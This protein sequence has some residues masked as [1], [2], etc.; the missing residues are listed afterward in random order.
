ML[1]KIQLKHQRRREANANERKRIKQLNE[2]I[3]RLKETTNQSSSRSVRCLTGVGRGWRSPT[4]HWDW[5]WALLFPQ[6]IKL[7]FIAVLCRLKQIIHHK[8]EE[9]SKKSRKLT[10]LGIIKSAIHHIKLMQQNLEESNDGSDL[11][12]S[13]SDQEKIQAES[14]QS[15]PS[16]ITFPT[17]NPKEE[18]ADSDRYDRFAED[19]KFH[20]TSGTFHSIE[21]KTEEELEMYNESEAEE[22]T[23][24][25]Y[26]IVED[27]EKYQI[28]PVVEQDYQ[29]FSNLFWNDAGAERYKCYEWPDL[30]VELSSVRGSE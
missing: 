25:E 28:I 11:N 21:V 23:E 9:K 16:I 29:V 26:V 27:A 14:L 2:A 8:N 24:G 1:Q 20:F 15:L 6:L 7:Y 4:G 30:P 13:C 3:K 5:D 19:D 10:K 22:E 18:F 12:P 17:L